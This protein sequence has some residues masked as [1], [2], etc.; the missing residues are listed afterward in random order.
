MR[1]QFVSSE[2]NNFYTY[3][4]VSFKATDLFKKVMTAPFFL[5]FDYAQLKPFCVCYGNKSEVLWTVKYVFSCVSLYT[6]CM[7]KV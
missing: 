6:K 1:I 2:C 3:I 4:L 5:S 7:E